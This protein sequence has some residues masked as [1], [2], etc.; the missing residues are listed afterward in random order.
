MS[1]IHLASQK[2]SA[3]TVVTETSVSSGTE[4]KITRIT[5]EFISCMAAKE[6]AS[7][8]EQLDLATRNIEALKEELNAVKAER[9]TL[10]SSAPRRTYAATSTSQAAA[11]LLFPHAPSQPA[12]T[13]LHLSV[14]TEPTFS[15]G[16]DLADIL[17]QLSGSKRPSEGP[18]AAPSIEL[19]R[20]LE[21]SQI[22]AKRQKKAKAPVPVHVSPAKPQRT[23]EEIDQDYKALAPQLDA[24]LRVSS[25]QLPALREQLQTLYDQFKILIE[26]NSALDH[27][28]PL[29]LNYYSLAGGLHYYFAE[30]WTPQELTS[31]GLKPTQHIFESL[32]KYLAVYILAEE[33]SPEANQAAAEILHVC[34]SCVRL[35]KE[36]NCLQ[37]TNE[38]IATAMSAI[39]K[40]PKS[41]GRLAALFLEFLSKPST[42]KNQVDPQSL[43][44]KIFVA[45]NNSPN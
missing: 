3:Q 30:C 24:A 7:L 12:T 27:N 34:R 41:R 45:L 16:T 20:R 13:R 31:A 38:E 44:K 21:E 1:G 32:S 29:L 33:N 6:L 19:G 23:L 37:H 14:E 9:D 35:S 15:P 28:L 10:L 26:P 17:M 25:N 43:F 22:P 42:Q 11:S 8:Q 36:L 39:W 4:T 5:E 2:C 18:L 40:E